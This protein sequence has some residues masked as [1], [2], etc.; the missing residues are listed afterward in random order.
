VDFREGKEGQCPSQSKFYPSKLQLTLLVFGKLLMKFLAAF[1]V[2]CLKCVSL[3]HFTPSI[4]IPYK[5]CSPKVFPRSTH[6]FS[7]KGVSIISVQFIKIIICNYIILTFTPEILL[8]MPLS[9]LST[10]NG[11]K[12]ASLRRLYKLQLQYGFT[13]Q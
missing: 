7:L 8:L 12:T 6:D 9:I 11:C 3:L 4:S 5:T 1:K 10:S 2:K 13:R